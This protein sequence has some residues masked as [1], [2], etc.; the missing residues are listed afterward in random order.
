[1]GVPGATLVTG[2]F[3]AEAGVAGDSTRTGAGVDICSGA[4]VAA[5]GIGNEGFACRAGGAGGGR[6][7]G[8]CD[9]SGLGAFTGGVFVGVVSA[10]GSSGAVTF[11]AVIGCLRTGRVS[12][13]E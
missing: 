5:G 1:M 12:G 7:K 3:G 11:C 8:T 10:G 6:D 13:R 2:V 4:R 9:K